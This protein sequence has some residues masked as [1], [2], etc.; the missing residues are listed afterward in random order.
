MEFRG[1]EM[2]PHAEMSLAQSLLMRALIGRFWREPYE[3]KLVRWGTGLHDRFMLP[4]LVWSDF[5]DVI[6][7]MNR[8]G[9]DFD[10]EW[11]KPHWEFRFPL[12]ARCN[13]K[14]SSWN[15]AP[16]WSPGM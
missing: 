11:F 13:M 10:A 9:F 1:F 8:H 12:W 6:D 2:P 4:H 7:D 3:Q 5:A 14:A 16:R 15:C